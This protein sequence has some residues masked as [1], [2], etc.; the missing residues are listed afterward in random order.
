MSSLKHFSTYVC[1]YIHSQFTSP[2]FIYLFCIKLALAQTGGGHFSPIAAYDAESDSV[3]V[4][5]VARFKYPPFWVTIEKLCQAMKTVEPVSGRPRGF[6]LVRPGNGHCC[7][8]DKTHDTCN[9]TCNTPH[10]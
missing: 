7:I 1:V 3:L 4:L 8:D 9:A 5:D 6:A 2:L 10:P